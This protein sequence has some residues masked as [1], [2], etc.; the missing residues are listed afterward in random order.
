MD[1]FENWTS[2]DSVAGRVTYNRKFEQDWGTVLVVNMEFV[3]DVD[4]IEDGYWYV[5]WCPADREFGDDLLRDCITTADIWEND[6][7][8]DMIEAVFS[9]MKITPEFYGA[10]RPG[11]AAL[12]QIG[13]ACYN[14]DRDL[15]E[16][17][18][19]FA[20]NMHSK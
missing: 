16:K 20:H 8:S 4:N 5:N 15:R 10:V 17:L 7:L 12:Q 18:V 13:R 6:R 19:K 11:P 9:D 3:V 1:T 2:I 14:I